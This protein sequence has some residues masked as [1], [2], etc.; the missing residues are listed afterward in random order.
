ME[1][2]SEELWE[3]QGEEIWGGKEVYPCSRYSRWCSMV[4]IWTPV[5][6]DSNPRYGIGVWLCGR[7]LACREGSDSI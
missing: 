4:G 7:K 1:G 5:Y 6:L 2:G 3:E